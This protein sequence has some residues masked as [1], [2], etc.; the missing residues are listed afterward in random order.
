MLNLLVTSFDVENKTDMMD[1]A[2]LHV[3][4]QIENVKNLEVKENLTLLQYYDTYWQETSEVEALYEV[5]VDVKKNMAYESGLYDIKAEVIKCD[6][7]SVLLTIE[8][9]HYYNKK[10]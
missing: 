1:M 9:K 7:K 4:N 2:T 6:E 3:S 5:H 8:T 10:E